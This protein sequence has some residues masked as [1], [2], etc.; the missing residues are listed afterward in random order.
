MIDLG[1]GSGIFALAA[2]RFGAR[3]VIGIDI[4]PMAIS[5]AKANAQLNGI[6]GVEFRAADVLRWRPPRGVSVATANLFSELLIQVLPKLRR[7]PW[8]ILS[9]VMRNQEREIRRVLKQNCFRILTVR[10]RGK[11]IAALA[12]KGER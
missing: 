3:H 4:D 1:T 2:K 5:T 9:G 11:W 10:R 6:A 8:L 12:G 7:I